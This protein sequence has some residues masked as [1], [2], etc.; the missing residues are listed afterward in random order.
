VINLVYDPI[1]EDIFEI[2]TNEN[3][4]GKMPKIPIQVFGAV[5][6]SSIEKC[7]SHGDEN[8][9]YEIGYNLGK[10]TSPKS[11]DE[12]IKIFKNM[13]L[14]NIKINDRIKDCTFLTKSNNEMNLKEGIDNCSII[15][16]DNPVAK[17]VK[18]NEPINYFEA[19]FLAGALESIF[20]KKVII[21]EVKCISQGYDACYFETIL[22]DSD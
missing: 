22:C 21:K 15:I 3:E 16:T 10:L 7:K 5:V 9:L 6:L 8:S 17:M 4:C 14:G 13:G 2:L 12:L 18:S 1:F 11:F 19:G 20:S